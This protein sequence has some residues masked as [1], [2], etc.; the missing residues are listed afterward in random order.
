MEMEPTGAGTAGAR[1]HS[2]TRGETLDLGRGELDFADFL[3]LV[4]DAIVLA[5]RRG[6][7]LHANAMAGELFGFGPGELAGKPVET[8]IPT[9]LLTLHVAHRERYYQEPRRRPMGIGLEL[10]G[11]RRDGTEFPAEI[12]LAP[13]ETPEDTLV[14]AAV[15][16]LT[17]R[18]EAER[19]RRE[20]EA[21]AD[22]AREQSARRLEAIGEL[23]GGIAHDFNNLLTVIG[24]N[25]R[26]ALEDAD[27][28]AREYL[29]EIVRAAD[30]G[31]DLTGQLLVFSRHG[32]AE[33]GPVDVNEV[34][35]GVKRLL[36]RTIGG[37]VEL[38]VRTAPGLPPVC[39]ARGQVEQILLNL[40]INARDA[41]AG[42]GHLAIATSRLD[43][44]AEIAVADDGCGMSTE[45]AERAFEP[46]FTTKP[47]GQ[48]TGLGLATVNG[49]VRRLGGH[50]ALTSELGR[51]T[52]V[53][54][55]LPF[56]GD[57]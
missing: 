8:L 11:R 25:A 50:V 28:A 14:V 27:P 18:V 34:V 10:H 3:E 30:H 9:R 49:I 22:G 19:R 12:S 45:V 33:L 15:R 35:S 21:E 44:Y 36:S 51:G 55:H 1:A 39:A 16:D 48:G 13:I 17:E 47:Q 31:A 42:G 26:F 46:F 5:D 24:E 56:A 20:L 54:V 23:A 43:G 2:E 29:E 6:Q 32:D 37:A 53:Q 40:A 4:P 7:I 52:R 38:D 57:A 41:M